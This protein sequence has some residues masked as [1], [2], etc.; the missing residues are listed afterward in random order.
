MISK[1]RKELLKFLP[2]ILSY[3]TI[4]K[5][6]SYV[7][8]KHPLA[9]KDIEDYLIHTTAESLDAFVIT[10]DKEFLSLSDRA[11]NVE[12]FFKL[13]LKE[14]KEKH[15]PFLDL[16]SQNIK[17]FPKVEKKLDRIISSSQFVCGKY[18][19]EFEKAF[20]SYLGAKFCIGVNSG[21][22]ALIVALMA[23]GLKPGDEVI[24]PVNTFIA[25][26]EAVSI[27]GGKPVF[28]DIHPDY[29]TID[30]NQIESKITNRTK[31]IIPVHLYGQCADMDPIM[32]I[33]RKYNLWII[34]DACQAHGAEYKGRKAGTIGHIG[35]FSF[36]PGKNLG[37]WGEAGA[38]VTNEE[39][40]AERMYK[41]RNHGGVKKYQHDILGGN[42]RM[43]EI[44]GVVLFEKLK[45]LSE[46]NEK[47]RH[48]AQI[49]KDH[50]RHLKSKGFVKLPCEAPYNKH[51]Y[52][53]FVVQSSNRN[54]L[55]Q[56]LRNKG[57][58]VGIHYPEPM[59]LTKAYKYVT[60]YSLENF[61]VAETIQG[62][63]ISLPMHELLNVKD[64]ITVKELLEFFYLKSRRIYNA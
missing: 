21:T 13:I 22:S 31:A 32:D 17:I 42:F 46:S 3:F 49:Y 43:E 24:M 39:V 60:N 37:S 40:L 44:Q 34:E 64:V 7:D 25:T 20:A 41:I 36:Y 18:V 8:W 4:W 47:R 23:V 33:A 15:V 11:I 26:A 29:Y 38:C 56:F 59:H 45:Y 27:L 35:C 53:L 28:V 9:Q 16:K 30:V 62:R 57:V 48:I 58:E 14:N 54:G 52:H 5:V 50:L 19:K 6:P 61:P 1:H 51:I 2:K 63:I 12:D 10:R 55:I